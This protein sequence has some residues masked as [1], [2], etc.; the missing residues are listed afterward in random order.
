[1]TCP[2][3]GV[4]R[5]LR[6]LLSSFRDFLTILFYGVFGNKRGGVFESVVVWNVG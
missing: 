2:V 3:T 1:V 6:L 4:I 5:L